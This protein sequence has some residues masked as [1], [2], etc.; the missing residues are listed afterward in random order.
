M[1][2]A[3]RADGCRECDC[4]SVRGGLFAVDTPPEKILEAIRRPEEPP[5]LPTDEANLPPFDPLEWMSDA[6]FKRWCAVHE[7]DY[8]RERWGPG[9]WDAE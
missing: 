2:F 6:E 4:T 1:F 5:I 7:P 3:H 8:Y 9:G